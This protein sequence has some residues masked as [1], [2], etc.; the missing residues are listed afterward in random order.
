MNSKFGG[1]QSHISLRDD[2]VSIMQG[3]FENG[4]SI[5]SLTVP[6]SVEYISRGALSGCTSLQTLSLPYLGSSS[7]D[8]SNA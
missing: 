2:T 1:S 3:A 6:D 7:S 5:T 4:G 8:S